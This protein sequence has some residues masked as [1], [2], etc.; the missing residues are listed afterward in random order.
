MIICVI[1]HRLFRFFF[2]IVHF[3]FNIPLPTFGGYINILSVYHHFLFK[4]PLKI[5]NN[6]TSMWSHVDTLI[7][8]RNESNKEKFHKNSFISIKILY[9]C[10][11]IIG[12]SFYIGQVNGT[13]TIDL[14]T[15]STTKKVFSYLLGGDFITQTIRVGTFCFYS[16]DYNQKNKMSKVCFL[17]LI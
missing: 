16:H 15:I 9:D 6:H 17:V 14:E 4:C 5:G 2:F 7:H 10:G 1:T 13:D 3:K 8:I 11:F 12:C